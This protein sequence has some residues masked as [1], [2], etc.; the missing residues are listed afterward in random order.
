M[1]FEA[2]QS[3][4]AR[5]I[6]RVPDRV[7]VECPHGLL[8]YAELDARADDV[9]VS[10]QRAGVRPA[11]PVVLLAEDRREFVAA[12]VGVLRA[13]G[14][15]IPLDPGSDPRTLRRVVA[16]LGRR[17]ATA[18]VGSGERRL[19]ERVLGGPA[20]VDVTVHVPCTAG[21]SGRGGPYARRP[22][23]GDPCC[24]FP[25]E[26]GRR[27]AVRTL[28]SVDH[29]IRRVTGL[30]RPGTGCRVGQLGPLGTGT[31]L[32]D[33]FVPLTCGGTVCVP[34]GAV[35]RDGAAL[36][37]WILDEAITVVHAGPATVRLLL[38]AP[39]AGRAGFP[40]LRQ[41]VLEGEELTAADARRW[42][43]LFGERVPLVHFHG[44][45]VAMAPCRVPG[46]PTGGAEAAG[47]PAPAPPGRV[48]HPRRAEVA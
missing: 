16:G 24:A 44:S 43:D 9:A 46:P 17:A 37:R 2:I 23:P 12:L 42:H 10:L 8:T 33:V 22:A 19:A 14:V 31:V 20:P 26:R 34:S 5:T 39:P 48:W 15:A 45:T 30:L 11:S 1:A 27:M 4:I 32:R 18:L 47:G 41:V 6:E 35:R 40:A 36:R 3:L 7:A 28:G 21:V 38:D 25:A 13:G 29:D